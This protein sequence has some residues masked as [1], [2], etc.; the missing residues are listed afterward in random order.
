MSGC[1][2]IGDWT[3]DGRLL[4]D[5]DDPAQVFAAGRIGK[6]V[7]VNSER[8]PPL[9]VRVGERIRLRLIN[10]ANARI[11]GLR[12]ERHATTVIALDGQPVEPFAPDG[13]RIVVAPGQR[14]DLIIDMMGESGRRYVVRDD[15][16]PQAP[17]QLAEIVY[18]IGAPVREAR[19]RA[20]VALTANPLPE[21][22]LA[23]ATLIAFSSAAAHLA[24]RWTVNGVA[25]LAHDDKPIAELALGQSYRLHLHNDTDVEHPIHLHGHSFRVLSVG[26]ENNARREWRDTVLLPRRKAVEVAL[27]A[28]NPG[29]WM[30]HCHILEH[31]AAG[32]M[33]VIRV[34]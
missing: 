1:S 9:G 32:M 2:T 5:Y 33:C 34:A 14:C 7:T 11:F 4:A 23:H 25:H 15:Y 22:D 17:Y 20:P 26:G 16:D 21:P 3:P 12:F 28:D 31:Q 30:L 10:A 8:R 29:N 27:V 13:G 24:H 6:T 19:L 18:G